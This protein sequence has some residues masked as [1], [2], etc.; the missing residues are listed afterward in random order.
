MPKQATDDIEAPEFV[1]E[2]MALG[3]THAERARKLGVH[4]NTIIHMLRTKRIPKCLSRYMPFPQCFAALH[5]DSLAYL[6]Q[7]KNN[8]AP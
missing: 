2:V 8:S 1:A 3:K 6:A 5:R 4:E 7:Q